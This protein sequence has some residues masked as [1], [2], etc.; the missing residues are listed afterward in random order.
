M[1]IYVHVHVCSSVPYSQYALYTCVSHF[2]CNVMYAESV[3]SHLPPSLPP[4]SSLSGGVNVEEVALGDELKV[5]THDPNKEL[6]Y[7]ELEHFQKPESPQHDND[8]MV[9]RKMADEPVSAVCV[10]VCVCACVAIASLIL[11]P[12]LT[13]CSMPRY[14]SSR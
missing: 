4:L 13:R 1:Y 2:V 10:C 12:S 8:A 7:A 5:V 6:H 9:N 14:R 11:S 3:Y